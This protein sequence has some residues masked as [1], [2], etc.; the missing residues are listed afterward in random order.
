MHVVSESKGER[1]V[2]ILLCLILMATVMGSPSAGIAHPGRLNQD[3]C[4]TVRKD[5]IYKSGKVVRKGEY[6]CHRLLIG[7]PAVLDGSEVLA[8]RG[9]EQK[10]EEAERG[11]EI[12]SP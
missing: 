12:Q 3:G 10:D 5:F 6:H 8:D 1:E 7:K 9:D 4:H 2:K 11:E